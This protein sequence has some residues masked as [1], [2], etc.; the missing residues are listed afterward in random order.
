MVFE[1]LSKRCE[2]VK[3]SCHAEGKHFMALT[4]EGEVYSWGSG[5]GGKLGHGDTRYSIYVL[6]VI[7]IF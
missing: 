2:I 7:I 4:R 3:V 5:D 6:N 1:S